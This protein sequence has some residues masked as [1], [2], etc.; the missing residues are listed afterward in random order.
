MKFALIGAIAALALSAI[1]STAQ[2]APVI[3]SWTGT[4]QGTFNGAAFTDTP[5]TFLGV[6]DTNN[7]DTT[8]YP[9]AEVIALD[10][11][12]VFLQ[13]FGSFTLL[14]PTQI[15]YGVTN[16]SM[17]FHQFSPMQR[18]VVDV[19]GPAGLSLGASIAPFTD[20]FEQITGDAIPTS[21]GILQFQ[22]TVGDSPVTFSSQVYPDRTGGVPE[23]ASWALMLTGFG[24]MGALLRR[25]RAH[26]A[27]V[28]A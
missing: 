13:G 12:S 19:A 18:Q 9:D 17:Y 26:L 8:I 25:R 28:T 21:G 15:A 27:A 24:G 7:I 5:F 1:G 20:T 23:P 10:S 16:G 6:G 11:V 3:F 4:W 22:L 14:N 2:A